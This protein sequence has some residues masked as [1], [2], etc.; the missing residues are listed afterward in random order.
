MKDGFLGTR[1]S[2]MLDLVAIA[3]V[4]A[5]PVL[6][7]SIA[8]AKYRKAYHWHRGIQISLACVLLVALVAFEVEMRR[9]GWRDRAEASRF[10]IDGPFNDW[11][12]YSL[13]VHLLFAIPTPLIWLWV[14]V[15]AMRNFAQ[16]LTPGPHS[17]SHRRW[18]MIAAASLI[19]TAVTGWWF[20]WCA[21]VA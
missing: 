1:A 18:G 21:F 15:R 7:L 10:W 5:I 6:I 14:I 4:V 17:V 11:I 19:L 3:L 13:A 20:Y 12:E 16:P 2:F 8:L 9:F